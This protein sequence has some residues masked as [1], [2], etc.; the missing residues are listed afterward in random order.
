MQHGNVSKQVAQGLKVLQGRIE[1]SKIPSSKIDE[2]LN[3]A[4]WNIREFGRR[5]RSEAAIHYIAEVM[6]QFDL[7]ALVELRDDLGDLKRVLD[8][9]GPTWRVLYSDYDA[10]AAGNHERIA[11]V[12]DKRAVTPTGLVSE[13]NPPRHKSGK[14]EYLPDFTWWRSPYMA[15]F[16]SGVFDFILVAHHTRWASSTDESVR[17]PELQ[18][19]ADWLDRRVHDAHVEDH[20]FI[21]VGDFNIPSLE[22]PLYKA[23][24]S[25]GLKMP[26]ALTKVKGSDLQQKRRYDQILHYSSGTFKDF[27]GTVDFFADD[28]RALFPAADY[29]KMTP[30]EFT[31]QMSDHEP[32]WVQIDTDVASERLDDILAAHTDRREPAGPPPRRTV[33]PIA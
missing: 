17:L 18:G 21:V 16:R 26:A 11:F 20:D 29:P 5:P 14:V 12:Y 2:T 31:Y 10:D 32:L 3:L 8:V 25:K 9:L 6:G 13:A 22:S 33:Q 4:S 7:I 24:T 19:F 30:K 28:W 1:K 27:G 15:S 23:L